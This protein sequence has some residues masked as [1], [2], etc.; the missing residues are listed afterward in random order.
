MLRNQSTV[1]SDSLSKEALWNILIGFFY[2]TAFLD[3][4]ASWKK[5]NLRQSSLLSTGTD[6]DTETECGGTWE[7]GKT[8][9]SLHP[10][11]CCLP[12]YHTV[13][14]HHF[15]H[16]EALMVPVMCH[17]SLTM[18][19]PSSFSEWST[20]WQQQPKVRL[21][22]NWHGSFAHLLCLAIIQKNLWIVF[23]ILFFMT[24]N[25]HCSCPRVTCSASQIQFTVGL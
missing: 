18:W 10:F 21:S 25:V 19:I 13:P 17:A 20:G 23:F 15:V 9:F 6:S 2:P 5:L 1:P 16:E 12:L 24:T 11:L 7:L 4:Q 22:G 14:Q 8:Q 3:S